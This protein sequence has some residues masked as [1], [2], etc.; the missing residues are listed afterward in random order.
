MS[1]I[2]IGIIGSNVYETTFE[3]VF[4]KF[5]FE[6][7]YLNQCV[8]KMQE[9]TCAG[10]TYPEMAEFYIRNNKC[11]RTNSDA[12]RNEMLETIKN[13]GISG[14]IVNTLKFCDFYPFDYIFLQRSLDKNFPILEIEHDLMS[15]DEGQIMT[16]L[17]AFF[18]SIKRACRAGRAS[19]AATKPCSRRACSASSYFV[20]IDI[21]SHAT[22]LVC[23]NEKRRILA[24]E[25]IP[26]GTSVKDNAKLGYEHLLKKAGIKHD[27][28]LNIISTGYGRNSIAFALE[29]VTEITCHAIGANHVL[30][31]GG[32][33]I[34]IGGQDSKA[35]KIDKE[36]TVKKFAMNDKCAAGTGRFL[37]VIADKLQMSL[38][39]FVKLALSAKSG[40][41]VSSMCSVFA[42]SEVI[43]LIAAGVSKEEISRG[44]HQSIAVRT[45]SLVKRADGEPP[46]Y[47]T[48]GVA[49]N[50]AMVESLSENLGS[51]ITV[52]SN[53]QTVGALGAA[54]FASRFPLP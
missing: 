50:M 4:N 33:I 37:E 39:E 32:T 21:G 31:D 27:H 38:E 10:A 8:Q 23:I 19:S 34:D 25:I 22:K 3:K 26:T 1:M 13:K 7:V 30:K 9:K 49:K 54:I 18:E 47:M 16:R 14:V 51:K 41:A 36:G 15:R 12:Y 40:V 6:K 42:E 35:I 24:N 28:V 20:G 46:Y 43:S 2:K 11:P 29:S 45:A 5:G 17:E 44:I 52:I 53:P 48:G